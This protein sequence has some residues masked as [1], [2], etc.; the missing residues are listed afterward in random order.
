MY[1]PFLKA[2]LNYTNNLQTQKEYA[3]NYIL[4]SI[5]ML[6]MVFQNSLFNNVSKKNLS[7]KAD[8]LYYN[9]CLY[10][11][12]VVLFGILALG[13]SISAYSVGLGLLFGIVTM[14]SNF[15]KLSALSKGPMHITILITTSSMII[16]AMSGFILFGEPFSIGKGIAILT[17]I[18]FIYLSLKREKSEKIDK[19]W[20]FYCGAAFLFQGIIGIIQ[21]IHQSSVHKDEL[22]LFLA[23]SFLFSFL[24]ARIISKREKSSYQF[25]KKQYIF[26]VIC[27]ICTFIM[28]YLNL[29]LSGVLPSQFFFPLINGGSIILTSLISITVFKEKITTLQLIGLIGGIISLIF[30]CI[31]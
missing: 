3:M 30:I 13:G 19:T 12:C 26:A 24:F 29:K 14:L 28:N 27:G 21:K 7:G 18:L 20:I 8:T 16:P 31:L 4:L 10:I 23:V 15:Y 11:V 9:S 5:S 1:Y 6:S 2:P 22:F 17:L 25:E